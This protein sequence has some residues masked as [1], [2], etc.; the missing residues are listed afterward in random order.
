MA[1]GTISR[2]AKRSRTGRVQPDEGGDEFYFTF[3]EITNAGDHHATLIKSKMTV[4]YEITDG[5][6]TKLVIEGLEEIKPPTPTLSIPGPNRN[7]YS[8]KFLNPYNFVQFLEKGREA[9][10]VL[11][12]CAPPPHDRYVGL[13]GSITCKLSNV[14]PLFISDS[15]EVKLVVKDESESGKSKD[16]FSYRFFSAVNNGTQEQPTIPA[17]SMRGML[18]SI[19]ETVTNSC[20]SIFDAERRLECR[21]GPEYGKYVKGNA[22]IVRKLARKGEPG[23]VELC[24]TASIGA[25]YTGEKGEEKRQTS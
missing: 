14:T 3:A 2:W 24:K 4:S 7:G 16:H 11:G 20:L 1:K 25:Y 10:Q 15:H 9:D 22:A 6:L 17:S 8:D 19:F 18:R 13:T 5:K 23:T 21:E 12:N